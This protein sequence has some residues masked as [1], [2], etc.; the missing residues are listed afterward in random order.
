MANT[1]TETR[2]LRKQDT[3]EQKRAFSGYKRLQFAHKATFGD[4]GINLGALT[5]PTEMSSQGF[6]QPSSV[7]ILNARFHV[8]KNNLTLVS[9]LRGKLIHG[10]SYTINSGRINFSDF[11]AEDGEIFSGSFESS[12]FASI[13][14]VDARPMSVTGPLLVGETDFNVG[15]QFEYNLNPTMQLGAV[16]VYRNGAQQFRCE[17]NT[18]SGDGNYIEVFQGGKTTGLIRFK[19]AA[20]IDDAIAVVANGA[21]VERPQES[22]MQYLESLSGKIDSMVPTL[23][24]L[25]GQPEAN[26]Q[27]ITNPD[28]KAFGDR[29]L[30]IESALNAFIAGYATPIDETVLSPTVAYGTEVSNLTDV[31]FTGTKIGKTYHL[32]IRFS[33]DIAAGNN[34]DSLNINLSSFPFFNGKTIKSAYGSVFTNVNSSTAPGSA[35]S[36]FIGFTVSTVLLNLSFSGQF[37]AQ[38]GRIG[39]GTLILVEE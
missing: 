18:L 39:V 35:V 4:T 14:L 36:A 6:V 13:P 21:L 23:A 26:F 33:F 7:D 12:R 3:V 32:S 16:Q 10:L 22:T 2:S 28:L 29:V 15:E 34:F 19:E 5:T 37:I 24:A 9:S 11:T 27:G 30:S 25:S 31:R 38:S 17:G 8:F 1:G 20:V